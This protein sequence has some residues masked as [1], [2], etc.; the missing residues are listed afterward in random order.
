MTA[1]KG[2]A[3]LSERPV[4]VV[5]KLNNESQMQNIEHGLQCQVETSS[6]ANIYRLRTLYYGVVR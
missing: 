3:R 2:L 5:I 6:R 4:R 1:K